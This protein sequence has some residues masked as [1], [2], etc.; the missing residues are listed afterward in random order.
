MSTFNLKLTFREL[1]GASG[2]YGPV[3]PWLTSLRTYTSSTYDAN[4]LP[5]APMSR[6]CPRL[7]RRTRP[8]VL[9]RRAVGLTRR[10]RW[11]PVL[12]A[13][14]PA[15]LNLNRAKNPCSMVHGHTSTRILVSF[16]IAPS[17][18]VPSFQ[19]HTNTSEPFSP[20]FERL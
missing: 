17:H 4:S 10:F 2:Q 1:E 18:H 16:L 9:F 15:T 14:G 7:N 5:I 13:E 20:P 8:P 3:S 6:N 19:A 12:S 11:A